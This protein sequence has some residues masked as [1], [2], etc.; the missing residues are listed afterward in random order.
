MPYCRRYGTASSVLVA[1]YLARI[2][3]GEG[4]GYDT[5][6]GQAY[7]A[8]MAQAAAK[9][10]PISPGPR[11]DICMNN[12]KILKGKKISKLTCASSSFVQKMVKMRLETPSV[13]YK[14][15]DESSKKVSEVQIKVHKQS[16]RRRK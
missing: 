2:G 10:P 15:F 5:D 6:G 16:K 3:V 13:N 12:S 11:N 4:G 9:T 1:L 7:A 14:L 8:N